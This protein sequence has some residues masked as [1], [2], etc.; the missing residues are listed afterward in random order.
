MLSVR[1]TPGLVLGAAALNPVGAAKDHLGKIQCVDAH[2][3]QGTPGQLRPHHPLPVSDGIAQVGGQHGGHADDTG[4]QNLVDFTAH[5][6]IAGP[7]GLS[8]QHPPALA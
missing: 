2:V 1:S 7:D 5:G 3:Q 4:G 8:D 6:L